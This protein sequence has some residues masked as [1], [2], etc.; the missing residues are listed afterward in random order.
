MRV[1]RSAALMSTSAGRPAAEASSGQVDPA[2]N[3]KLES[4]PAKE[5]SFQGNLGWPMRAVTFPAAGSPGPH[6]LMGPADRA[7]C[8]NGKIWI[9]AY[10]DRRP[11]VRIRGYDSMGTLVQFLDTAVPAA[12]L[13]ELDYDLIDENSL[14]DE[15]GRVRFERVVFSLAAGKAKETQRELFEVVP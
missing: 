9:V 12:K 5:P 10:A 1:Q 15:N 8:S 3:G 6:A 13:G 4:S 14:R 7:V 11:E 2:C